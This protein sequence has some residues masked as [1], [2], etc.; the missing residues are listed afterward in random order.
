[1]HELKFQFLEGAIKGDT[2]KVESEEGGYFNSSKVRLKAT[3][4]VL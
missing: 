4:P 3:I 1:M 2:L